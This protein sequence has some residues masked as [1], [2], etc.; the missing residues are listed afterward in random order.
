MEAGAPTLGHDAIPGDPSELQALCSRL[1]STSHQLSDLK[2][3]IGR[4][5]ERDWAGHASNSYRAALQQIGFDFIVLESSF[6]SAAGA[7]GS[8]VAQLDGFQSTAV[9]LA[10]KI[11]QYEDDLSGAQARVDAAHSRMV[12]ARA[13]RDGA[14]P[15]PDMAVKQTALDHAVSDVNNA[16]DD[17]ES[18][19]RE[20]ATL[21]RSADENRQEYESA[22]TRL[23]GELT[24][25]A[26]LARIRPKP[27]P[28]CAP[29]APSF[30]PQPEIPF[31]DPTSIL[32]SGGGIVL[33]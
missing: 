31:P 22:A 2:A 27:E 15:G 16:E 3:K 14:V 33:D 13:E 12:S 26:Q 9:W 6:E 4:Q 21:R 30:Q 8:F 23:A 5:T 19:E 10:N 20:I 29:P 17:V 1:T 32:D 28:D 24:D 11:S 18:I 25:V 7:I